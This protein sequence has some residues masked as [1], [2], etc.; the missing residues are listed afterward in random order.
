MA[1]LADN[2]KVFI[3]QRLAC[4]DSPQTVADAVKESYGLVIP[5][6]Q[7]EDYDPAKRPRIAARWRELHQA[8]REAFLKES[9]KEPAAHRAVRVRR[10]ARMAEK[11]E[12]ARN[13]VLA[14]DLYEQIAKEIGEA[15]TNRR[16]LIPGDPLAELAK[17]LGY[18]PE[19]LAALISV[20]G[21]EAPPEMGTTT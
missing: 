7:V 4:F 9:A 2:V 11:A 18:T 5:R 20:E 17:T 16:V 21:Q 10:L 14:K 13:F 3:V 19:Q 15:Y 1:K 12:V 6:Q 8:T